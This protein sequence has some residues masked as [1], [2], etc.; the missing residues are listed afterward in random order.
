MSLSPKL[1]EIAHALRQLSPEEAAEVI[2]FIVSASIDEGVAAAAK[3]SMRW[4]SDRL[5][6]G[7]IWVGQVERVVPENWR[8]DN[9]FRDMDPNPSPYTGSAKQ[10]WAQYERDEAT[11]WAAWLN[12]GSE[13]ELTNY[14]TEAAARAALEAVVVGA[15]IRARGEGQ[16]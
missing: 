15:F 12:S 7:R 1:M 9:L 4:D 8:D 5:Y 6:V 3:A 14:A 10:L 2:G 11:P 13:P 16:T